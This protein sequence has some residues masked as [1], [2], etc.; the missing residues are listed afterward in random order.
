MFRQVWNGV[1]NLIRWAGVIWRDRNWDYSFIYLLLLFKLQ[2][3]KRYLVRYGHSADVAEDVETMNICIECL[4]RLIADEYAAN[5]WEK[6]RGRWG[7]LK[8]IENGL[9]VENVKTPIDQK[10]YSLDVQRCISVEESLVAQDIDLLFDTMK[11][12]IRRWW[13]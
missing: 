5:E 4:K 8:F 2:G 6:M 13:D 9:E 7:E 12:N 10:E 3:M 11:E 1:G